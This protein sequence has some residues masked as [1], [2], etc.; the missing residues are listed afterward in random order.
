LAPHLLPSCHE[1]RLEGRFP[2]RALLLSTDHPESA[3]ADACAALTALAQEGE[4][5]PRDL[6]D[7]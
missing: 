6:P 5:E 3:T 2:P 4:S 7:P 1:L